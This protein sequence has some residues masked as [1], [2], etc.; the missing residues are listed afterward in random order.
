MLR[1][2]VLKMSRKQLEWRDISTIKQLIHVPPAWWS[3]AR[4]LFAPFI[5]KNAA[6]IIRWMP[7]QRRNDRGEIW[8]VNLGEQKQHNAICWHRQAR[9]VP[10]TSGSTM[11]LLQ[12]AGWNYNAFGRLCKDNDVHVHH[13]VLACWHSFLR[14][15]APWTL[16][17]RNCIESTTPRSRKSSFHKSSYKLLTHCSWYSL[18]PLFALTLGA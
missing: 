13:P 17:R 10:R 11:C 8:S 6:D 7:S 16:K 15:V 5:S 4:A 18:L 14:K 3:P 2:C 9:T 12:A 1:G